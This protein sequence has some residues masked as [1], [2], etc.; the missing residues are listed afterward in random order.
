MAERRLRRQRVILTC[1]GHWRVCKILPVRQGAAGILLDLLD[2]L[3]S[4]FDHVHRLVLEIFGST[5]A[6]VLPMSDL[7]HFRHIQ[8]FLNPSLNDRF[9][10]DPAD[11]FA[12]S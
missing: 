3:Q 4:E 6:R 2:Q 1:R 12:P 5:G 10:F 11:G 7:D 9:D 8:R